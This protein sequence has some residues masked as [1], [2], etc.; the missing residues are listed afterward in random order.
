MFEFRMP[1]ETVEKRQRWPTRSL[2]PPS[3]PFRLWLWADASLCGSFAGF[4]L[5]A[6]SPELYRATTD[7]QPPAKRKEPPRSE[8]HSEQVKPIVLPATASDHKERCWRC[9]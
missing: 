8:T 2:A 5:K 9:G 7:D 1:G 6:Q 3:S 4:F